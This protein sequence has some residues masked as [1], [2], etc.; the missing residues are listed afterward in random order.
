MTERRFELD[1]VSDRRSNSN[2]SVFFSGS[3]K[4]AAFLLPVMSR[5]FEE[6]P[7]DQPGGGGGGSYGVSCA[8]MSFQI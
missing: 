7:Y 2:E 8:F 4:T 6:G 1:N 5:I 3:G